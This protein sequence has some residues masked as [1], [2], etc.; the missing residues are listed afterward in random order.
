MNGT[1][2]SSNWSSLDE[3]S[4]PALASNLQ[5]AAVLI[6][7]QLEQDTP[8]RPGKHLEAGGSAQLEAIAEGK[9]CNERG[10]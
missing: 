5:Q 2:G 1:G 6:G 4:I 9:K 10:E 8:P 7:Q 3:V